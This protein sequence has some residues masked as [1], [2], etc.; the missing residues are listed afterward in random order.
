M[1]VL[2]EKDVINE[3]ILTTIRRNVGINLNYL[4][5]R[6]SQSDFIK[7]NK[8]IST[9]IK[10][11]LLCQINNNIKLTLSGMLMAD[12]ITSDLFII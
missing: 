9:L 10:K 11:K 5:M 1:E 12:K 2:S 6:I 4:E 8:E 7:L 3:Y